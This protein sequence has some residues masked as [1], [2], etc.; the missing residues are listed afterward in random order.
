[1]P[2]AWFELVENELADD[3][4]AV[5]PVERDCADVENPCD[6]CV[7]AEADEIDGDAPKD[8]NPDGQD[9]CASQR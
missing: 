4:N 2:R 6:C 3:W 9:G 1:M 8:S 7:R 5:A